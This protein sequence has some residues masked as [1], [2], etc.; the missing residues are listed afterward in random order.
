MQIH[1]YEYPNNTNIDTN[2]NTSV[3]TYTNTNIQYTYR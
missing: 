1:K 2:M 3:N